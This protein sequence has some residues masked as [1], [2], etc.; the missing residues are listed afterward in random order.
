[1]SQRFAQGDYVLGTEDAELARL[2]LQHAVW[3]PRASDA[4]RRAGFT[5]GQH[6]AD[7]GCGPGFATFDLNDVVG[8]SGRITALD[9]SPRFLEHLRECASRD[10]R[11]NIE[12]VELDLDSVAF[13]DIR[14]DG[15]WC[16]W[17]FA[18]VT[19]PR[20]LL[21]SIRRMMAPGG[22]IVIHEYF[23]YATMRLIPAEPAFEEFVETVKK[24]WREAGGEPDI[25][26]DLVS[27]LPL[28]GFRITSTQ[29][30]IHVA[31]P[32]DFIWQWPATFVDIS[33]ERLVDLGHLTS[34]RADAVKSAFHRA[35]GNPSS[36]L[37]TPGVLEII[38][39]AMD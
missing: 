15:A 32:A 34:E 14:V 4:W 6:L 29:P 10:G 21:R 18:F 12:V 7:I 19:K 17:V 23:D 26:L 31:S 20:N 3:R 2:G 5:A 1:M 27:W 36:R 39:E 8:R 38:A 13:P 22:A 24:S 33:A 25:A 9:R 35:G 11:A 28:E 37:V 16:R 30:I